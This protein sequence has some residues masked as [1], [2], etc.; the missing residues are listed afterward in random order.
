MNKLA[1]DSSA[2]NP[3]GCRYEGGASG[4]W[5]ANRLYDGQAEVREIPAAYASFP[6]V[7]DITNSI[8]RAIWRQRSSYVAASCGVS[9]ETFGSS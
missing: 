8:S 4:H 3:I 7:S 6:R 2:R 9:S 5:P 1:I